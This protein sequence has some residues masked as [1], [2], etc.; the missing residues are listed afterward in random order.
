MARDG[1]RSESRGSGV[2]I[3]DWDQQIS[4]KLDELHTILRDKL[5]AP[6]EAAGQTD[7]FISH[8][9]GVQAAIL[10]LHAHAFDPEH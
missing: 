3:T 6:G 9:W 2:W 7:V 1:V 8:N 10:L 5:G 4:K